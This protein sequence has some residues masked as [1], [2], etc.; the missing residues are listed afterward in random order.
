MFI[1]SFF[2]YCIPIDVQCATVTETSTC[3]FD[4][5]LVMDRSDS[6][7]SDNFA[8]LKSFVSRL[9][10]RLDIDSGKTRVAVAAF[11]RNFKVISHFDEHTTVDSLQDEINSYN[12]RGGTTD[13]DKAL[14]RVRKKVM[15]ETE[16]DRSNIR[17]VVV[18]FTAGKDNDI[19]VVEVRVNVIPIDEVYICRYMP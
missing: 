19:A 6:V 8:I 14:R 4:V 11:A 7:G 15:L 1:S 10:S 18:M 5:V 9:V 2:R 13:I 16:G 3:P 12:F 17:N